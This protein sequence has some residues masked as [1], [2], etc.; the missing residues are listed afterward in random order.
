LKLEQYVEAGGGTTK[1]CQTCKLPKALI[2][3]VHSG[4]LR[5]APIPYSRIASWLKSEGHDI[6]LQSVRNHFISGHQDA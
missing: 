6:S 5:D 2:D 1:K 4:R 3:Q